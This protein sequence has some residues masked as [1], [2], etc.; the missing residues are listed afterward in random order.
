MITPAYAIVFA[1]AALLAGVAIGAFVAVW[2]FRHSFDLAARYLR[3]GKTDAPVPV[4]ERVGKTNPSP[5]ASAMR[6]IT[7]DSVQRGTEM[8][9]AAA[10]EQGIPLTRKEAEAQARDMLAS[11]HPLG[12]VT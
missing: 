11:V 12:G 8:I 1:T 4:E 5:E 3:T 6:Q 9:M 2:T 7:E 10:K